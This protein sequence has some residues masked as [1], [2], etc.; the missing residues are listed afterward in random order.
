MSHPIFKTLDARRRAI[1]ITPSVLCRRAG[2]RKETYTRW[3]NSKR[4]PRLESVQLV[5]QALDLNPDT[6]EPLPPKPDLLEE[7]RLWAKHEAKEHS[8]L[9]YTRGDQG[10]FYLSE[11]LTWVVSKIDELKQGATK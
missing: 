5:C 4:K 2:I 10:D 9:F 6:L 11:A 7:L 3:K 8:L 1:G